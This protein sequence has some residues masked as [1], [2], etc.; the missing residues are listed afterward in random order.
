MLELPHTALGALIAVKI[1]NP[2]I[3]LPLAFLSHFVLDF[4]PHWNPSLYSE[5]KK[6]KKPSRK[7]NVIVAFDV[8]LSLVLGFFIAF[9][10]WPDIKRAVVILLACFAA[11]AADAVEGF[12]FYFGVKHPLLKKWVKFQHEHQT[13]AKL[14]FGLLTQI[15]A[16]I[17]CLYLALSI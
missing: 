12:F 11:V 2:L 3:S 16:L 4:V 8:F 5:T 7:S 9:R 10:F 17:F 15:A 13:N 6:F 14:P 1:P